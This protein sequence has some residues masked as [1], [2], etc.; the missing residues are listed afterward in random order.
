MA[1]RY[2][3]TP[4]AL[5][6]HCDGCRGSFDVNHTLDCKNGGL[7]Y[8]RHNELRDENID[9]NRKAGFSQVLCVP[10]VQEA[11][12]NGN[13]EKKGDWSVR[14]FWIPQ[15]VAVFDTRIFNANAPS[16]KDLTLE[17]TFNLHRNEKKAKYCAAVEHMR[18][19]FTPI[20]ATCEGILEHAAEAYVKRLASHLSGRWDDSLSHTLFLIQARLQICI[21]RSVSNCFRG[22][23]CKWRGSN[24][25]DRA[26]LP[27]MPKEFID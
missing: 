19:S 12:E 23:R 16:Y 9:L 27:Y 26:G 1:C 10:V 22:S 6:A 15:R 2:A 21:L 13:G 5:Q 11:D 18:G 14:G 17:A 4:R 20:I 24:V 3:E 7:V 8:Q 25:E